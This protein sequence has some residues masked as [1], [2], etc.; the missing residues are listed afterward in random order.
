MN[1]HSK[2]LQTSLT[3]YLQIK[4]FDDAAIFWLNTI[5]SSL[6]P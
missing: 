3:F 1:T 5:R 6:K 2:V 4:Q